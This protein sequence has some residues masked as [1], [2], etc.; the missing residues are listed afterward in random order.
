MVWWL[1]N[2]DGFVLF[3]I[4]GPQLCNCGLGRYPA[5]SA[6]LR[7]FGDGS[8]GEGLHAQCRLHVDDVQLCLQCG[9]RSGHAKENKV[10][11]L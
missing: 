7:A 4:D 11:Q 5:C 10:D 8:I 1:C 9:L 2:W 6:E 3:W